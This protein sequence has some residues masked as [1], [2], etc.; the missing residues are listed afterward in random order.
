[1]KNNNSSIIA[2]LVVVAIVAAVA[3]TFAILRKGATTNIY[4]PAN[5][6]G[7]QGGN[8]TGTGTGNGTANGNPKADPNN[9]LTLVEQ[10]ASTLSRLNPLTKQQNNALPGTIINTLKRA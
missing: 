3:I 1:M 8:G 7:G 9:Q 2:I 4:W 5:N 6:S 10:T